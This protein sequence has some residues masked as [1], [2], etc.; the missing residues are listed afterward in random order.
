[1]KHLVYGRLRIEKDVITRV[2]RTLRGKGDLVVNIGQQ[3]TPEEIIGSATVSAGFR[4]LNLSNILSVPPHE[5]EKLLVRKIG[6]RIYKD[7]LL[8][9][10]K[11]W[12][13][14]DKK[15]ITAP[16][17]G[18]LDFLNN[19]TGEL[20]IAFLPKKINLPAG[21][22]GIVEAVDKQKGQA[23]IRTQASRIHGVFGSG[24]SRDGTLHILS[25]K[26]GLI[27][28]NMVNASY[29]QYILVGGS[30]FFKDAITASIS[31]GVSGV[32]TGGINAKDYRGMAGGRLVF[33]KKLYNDIGISVVVC[34]GFGSIPMGDDIF[35]LLS[36]YEGK[37]VFIDGNKAFV[38][39]PS[40]S[41]ASLNKIK[42]SKL[43]EQINSLEDKDYTKV[44]SELNVGCKVRIVGNS[45]PGEQ[46][47][48]LAVNDSLTLFPSGVR[49]F[50]ATIET[51][52]RKIQVPVA[53]LEVMM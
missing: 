4:T 19:K 6:E 29:D 32:I 46:G 31:N 23:V 35:S 21:V 41:G 1:M 27:S 28:K 38:G 24:R 44:I 47:K 37:F 51:A 42:N 40:Y 2:I 13:F 18:V 48:L 30:L 20:K 50:L 17:D 12:L 26:D 34:E 49:D 15:V 11:G 8:A 36:E 16:T 14:G 3:V 52:R 43:P 53:N 45:Y 10:K 39:L 22:Y 7:E 33:P 25:K 9:F 5:V